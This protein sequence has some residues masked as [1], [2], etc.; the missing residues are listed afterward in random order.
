MIP[1]PHDPGTYSLPINQY[2][3][4]GRK[5]KKDDTRVTCFERGLGPILLEYKKLKSEGR[6]Y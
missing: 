4:E 5:P 6:A 3:C 1:S 2:Y